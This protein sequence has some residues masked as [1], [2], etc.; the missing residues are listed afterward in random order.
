MIDQSS[1]VAILDNE[2]SDRRPG[3][4]AAVTILPAV[5]SGE[6]GVRISNLNATLCRVPRP[7]TTA[8]M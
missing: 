8:V 1:R 6:E 7:W 4:T 2:V 5:A 3:T